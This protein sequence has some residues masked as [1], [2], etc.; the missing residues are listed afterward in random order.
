VVELNGRLNKC[1]VISPRYDIGHSEVRGATAG[2]DSSEGC[3][4]GPCVVGSRRGCVR[5]AA[6]GG[7]FET[8]DGL[9]HSSM[10]LEGSSR[11]LGICAVAAQ[12]GTAQ[13]RACGWP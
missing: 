13:H 7:L 11:G 8:A 9:V 5:W 6:D 10:G 1:G 3:I 12:Q 4:L 2:G